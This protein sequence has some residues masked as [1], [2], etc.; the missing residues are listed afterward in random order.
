MARKRK[1]NR[2]K[3]DDYFQ[4]GPIEFARFGK[5]VV[6]RSNAS[7]DEF[8]MM[9][10]GLSD[11]LP[12]VVAEIDTLVTKIASRVVRFA[13][14]QLLLRAWW[15][16]AARSIG[17]HTKPDALDAAL[18]VIEYVQSVIAS[19]KPGTVPATELTE[20]D[21]VGLT[22]DIT[23]LFRRVS[24]EYQFSSTANRRAQDPNIN[25]GLEEFRFRAEIFWVNVRGK[26]YQIHER[27]AL[28]D[29]LTPHSEVLVRQFGLDVSG[30]VSALDKIL[31]KLT[32]GLGDAF[33]EMEALRAETSERL[34][35]LAA[36]SGSVDI[37]KLRDKLFEDSDLASRRDRVVGEMF[38][39][40]LFDVQKVT[41]L[42]KVLLDEL[43]WSPGEDEEV[44]CSRRILR[45]A[46]S[47]LANN[48]APIHQIECAGLLL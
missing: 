35:K 20:E 36:K 40:D 24:T 6:G 41:G 37:G 19:V 45:M 15:Q 5:I 27:Q 28:I 18:R 39:L 26:R 13:P 3:P 31:A 12:T 2:G 9:Q 29:V 14:E 23:T 10:A 4:A 34:A 17:P 11:H 32:H 22:E 30:L 43:T 25:M 47:R 48:E 21:L 44:L 16:F 7:V 1:G 33:Q 46:P 42:P 38:G 8:K